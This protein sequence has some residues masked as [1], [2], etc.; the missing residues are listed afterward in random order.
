MGEICLKHGI[1]IC[2]DE[3]H[4]EILYQGVKHTPIASLNKEFASNAITFMAPSKTFN[5]PGLACSVAIIQNQ[6]L[7][8]QFNRALQ[9]LGSFV[10]TLSLEAGLAAYRDCDDWLCELLSYLENNRNYAQK[11]F[12][13]HIPLIKQNNIDATFLMWLDC[14]ALPIKGS[15]AEFFSNEAHVQLNDGKTFG[16]GYDKY[17]R[18]NFG[19]NKATLEAALDNMRTA[20]EKQE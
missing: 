16:K 9:G 8:E 18:L 15:P 6:D 4:C 3:I 12:H 7:R 1:K 13:E 2:S 14:S 17:V 20:L 19:T 5:I 10:S 11:Y